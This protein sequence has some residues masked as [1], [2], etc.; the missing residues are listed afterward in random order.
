MRRCPRHIVRTAVAVVV[1]ALGPT[2]AGAQPIPDAGPAPSD[3]ATD[4]GPAPSDTATDAG[5][6]PTGTASEPEIEPH[7]G[8]GIAP[9][10]TSPLGDEAT[11]PEAPLD[12]G[13]SALPAGVTPTTQWREWEIRGR[14]IDD[15]DTVRGFME[16]VMERNRRWGSEEQKSVI[17]FLRTIGYYAVIRNEP[18]DAASVRAIIEVEPVTR[19]RHVQVH[20]ASLLNQLKQPVFHDEIR[21]RMRL[22]PGA[23]LPLDKTMRAEEIRLEED[24]IADYLR[25]NG[26]FE[27]E[28]HIESEAD[29]PHAVMLTVDIDKGPAYHVGKVTVSGNTI[30]DQKTLAAMFHH[31]RLCIIQIC[32]GEQRFSR[33]QL[34]EDVDAIVDVYQKRGYPAVRVRTDFDLRHSFKRLTHTV[35]VGVVITERSKI[36]VV[37]LGNERF[38]HDELAKLLT[39]SEEGSYD[40]VEVEHSATEI[41]RYYQSRGYFEARVTW[42]RVKFDFFDRILFSIDEGP[43]LKVR[44]IEIVG[45]RAIPDAI[46]RENLV[47]EVY[48]AFTLVP[49][50]G[51]ATSLQLSQDAERIA[52]MYRQRG[53]AEVVVTAQAARARDLLD[54]AAALAASVAADVD[55]DGL[56]VRFTVTEGARLE[57]ENVDFAI[58]GDKPAFSD[59]RLLDVVALD[60]GTPYVAS[61]L[62]ADTEALRRFYFNRGYPAAQIESHAE[63]G[64]RPDRMVIVHTI[65]EHA[66]KR[67]GKIALRGNFKTKDWVLREELGLEEGDLLTA[68]RIRTAQQNLQQSGL[69]SSVQ[70]DYFGLEDNRHETVNLIVRVEERHD[71]LASVEV[72][73]GWSTDSSFFAETA[74]RT[75]NIAGIGA[76]LD[77]RVQWGF[78]LRSVDG[79]LVFPRWLLRH[80]LSTPFVFRVGGFWR[81]EVTE[82]FGD[83]ETIGVT[84]AATKEGRRGFF[85]N[86]LLS[87]RYD[88]RR[89]NRD[90]DLIRAPGENGDFSTVPVS[91]DT[92]AIGPELIIDKRRDASGR[93]NPLSPASG[94]R[95]EAR[96]Q[97]A[98]DTLFGDARFIKLGLG[99]QNY[100]QLTS[101]LKLSSGIRYDHGFPLGGDV[102]LP[103]VE[104]FFAGGDTR[105]RGFDE[106]RLKT[107]AIITPLPPI[108]DVE[109][110]RLRPAGGNIRLMHT[111]DLE[112]KVWEIKS[113]PVAS[114][115]FLDTGLVTNSLDGFE[116]TDLRHSIGVAL[117]RIVSPVG[118]LSLEW[119]IP[120]DP[121][122]GDNPRGR[123]HIN[124]GATLQL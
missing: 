7:P 83:L 79:D 105:V 86:W 91:T 66:R 87:L 2:V 116:I 119:A 3:T 49:S 60:P 9:G 118:S 106:D 68:N 38:N 27:A 85:K 78:E 51:F 5:P 107:E 117:F 28:V 88:F 98:E 89:R 42:E 77:T 63:P 52:E 94:F 19:V 62:S 103:E 110:V 41:R 99:L 1:I 30:I 29:G 100:F 59:S 104:R 8:A 81:E 122:I 15:E 11:S 56:F 80:W 95:F 50:G 101:R 6:A 48:K 22:R 4:A 123:F 32:G 71:Y 53:Y 90:E 112:L 75:R 47:T 21:H 13:T 25:N 46:L 74:L 97:Y 64:T 65:R 43:R 45:N 37:F 18:L 35:D 12:Q 33:D 57:I 69:F 26:F 82:R 54:N 92:S 113:I 115:I 34:N 67:I 111:L 108:Y 55:T 10:D 102:L 114:G 121:Q 109:R 14:L 40:D 23:P 84:V 16:P 31:P 96:A 39:F 61:K 44:Q 76:Q 73:G 72:G 58:D 120:L 70:L 20:F 36:D 17:Q 124:I 93:L 24:R